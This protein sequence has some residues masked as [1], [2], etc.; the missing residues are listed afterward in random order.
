[1]TLKTRIILMSLVSPLLAC[2]VLGGAFLNAN[3]ALEQRFQESTLRAKSTL[4]QNILSG[5]Y[6]KMITA[7]SSLVRDR[8]FKNALK[9]SDKTVLNENVITSFRLF[10]ASNI[11]SSIQ[12]VDSNSSVLFSTP[13]SFSGITRKN[14]PSLSMKDGKV[15]QGVE[16]DD[17]GQLAAFVAFPVQKRG[18]ILGAGIFGLSLAI[19]IE[20]LK[21]N[22]QSDVFIFDQNGKLQ[23]ATDK[24]GFKGVEF[25]L[26]PLG[27]STTHQISIENEYFYLTIQPL[28]NPKEN[29]VGYLVTAS[30]NTQNYLSQRTSNLWAFVIFLGMYLAIFLFSRMFLIRA[31]AP[32]D[33]AIT[34]LGDIAKGDLTATIR[35]DRHGETGKL[36]TSMEVML[37]NLS[38]MVTY[39]S[40]SSGVLSNS[41]HNLTD[42]TEKTNKDILEQRNSTHQI[43]EA[44]KKMSI[45]VG[46]IEENALK[47]KV[48]ADNVSKETVTGVGLVNRSKQAT[49]ELA[50]EVNVA[51]MEISKLVESSEEISSVLHSIKGIADQTN[52]LALNAAIEAA[53][54]GE[55]GRGFAVVADEVRNLAV[56]T[57]QS[58]DEIQVML[59][60]LTSGTDAVVAVM[61]SGSEH[62]SKNVHLIGQASDS[63]SKIADSIHQIRESNTDTASA[64]SEQSLVANNISGSVIHVQDVADRV[65]DNANEIVVA[66][67]ALEKVAEQLQESVC[68]F[69]I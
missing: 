12:I 10:N 29:A 18:K 30:N 1:M 8:T 32:L 49:E 42:I 52:L 43:S 58:T 60:K 7:S 33:V 5:Q 35:G 66:S 11:L 67:E 55:Q 53:R 61:K 68:K 25:D 54:A 16:V 24:A 28:F 36:L 9:N 31:F 63:L 37:Q 20:E 21:I 38:Q 2:S 15:R 65:S 62:A 59:T 22:D 3:L 14:L 46:E 64:A 69:R 40:R 34:V 4:W 17:N 26:P 13:H 41:S 56:R 51:S 39:I 19:S 45:S 57:Q 23:Q 27:D 6:E 47:T 48:D 44:I 50:D